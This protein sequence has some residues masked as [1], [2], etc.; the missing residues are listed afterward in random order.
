V[1]DDVGMNLLEWDKS[2]LSGAERGLE[3]AAVFEN[4]FAGIPVGKAEVE[5]LLAVE[6]ADAAGSSAEA[7]D[8]PGEFQERL[9][10]ENTEVADAGETP[11]RNG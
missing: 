11:R 4:V 9:D 6:I 2:E 8:K 10:L 3:L 7:V 1:I 5:N